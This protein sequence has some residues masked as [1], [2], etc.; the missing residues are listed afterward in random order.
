MYLCI[1]VVFFLFI[2]FVFILGEGELNAL[3][4]S[5][6][7]QIYML[8]LLRVNSS[9]LGKRCKLITDYLKY[10]HDIVH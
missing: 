4:C 2:H 1:Y 10:F 7:N 5:I 8:V 9:S 6:L 3:F